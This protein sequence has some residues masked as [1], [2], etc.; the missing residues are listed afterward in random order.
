MVLV[1]HL[2]IHLCKI[3]KSITYPHLFFV[4]CVIYHTIIYIIVH[5]YH[6]STAVEKP[7]DNSKIKK[8]C[9]CPI[10]TRSVCVYI[11]P[12][13]IPAH[14]QSYHHIKYYLPQQI[15][16]NTTYHIIK[17]IYYNITLYNT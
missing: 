11:P 15:I 6:L 5:F 13:H 17:H 8:I 16:I 7:V 4:Q 14:K 1:L 12:S 3:T 9:R 2:F 10:I